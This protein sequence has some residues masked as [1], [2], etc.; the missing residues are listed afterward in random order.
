MRIT[1]I[2]ILVLITQFTSAQ[3][4]SHLNGDIT[5]SLEDETIDATY[6]ITNLPIDTQTL[7]FRLNEYI[8]VDA[9]YL[10]GD[11]IAS[12]KVPQ[13]CD[14]CLIYTVLVGCEIEINP[15][16]ELK[17]VTRGKFKKFEDPKDAKRYKGQLVYS[18]GVLRAGNTDKWYPEIVNKSSNISDYMNPFIYTYSITAN[19]DTCDKIYIGKGKPQPSGSVFTNNEVAGDL[20]LL[21]GDLN[22]QT[23]KYANYINVP[24][25]DIPQLEA[26]FAKTRGFLEELTQV[27]DDDKVVYAQISSPVYGNESTYNTIINTAQN[28]DSDKI[29]YAIK[30]SDAYYYL[31]SNF[32]P[33]NQLDKMLLQSLAKYV[34]LKYLKKY[35]PNQYNSLNSY[36]TK[37]AVTTTP[38]T[39]QT[40]LQALL[41][42]PQQFVDLENAIGEVEMSRFISNMFQNLKVGKR[43]LQAFT[44]S[45]NQI[46]ERT[47]YINQFEKELVNQFEMRSI[48]PVSEEVITEY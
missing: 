31:A 42:T 36:L 48:I 25:K 18:N 13:N 38:T 10:N 45:M 32:K 15:Q 23:G 33:E 47:D 3:K 20:V 4:L 24:E 17:I 19:C 40:R 34:K 21:A 26:K 27:S 16:S 28:V 9:I 1:L 39:D 41:I 7:S 12:S 5:I 29:D 11:R 8:K 44:D 2:L 6:K 14:D 22:Y 46:T 35:N 43:S 30:E 37:N